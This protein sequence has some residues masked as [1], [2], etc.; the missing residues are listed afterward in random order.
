MD[1]SGGADLSVRLRDGES[2]V[3]EGGRVA[4]HFSQRWQR[5]GEVD[6]SNLSLEIG[7][8]SHTLV[9]DGLDSRGEGSLK[10]EVRI[11]GEAEEVG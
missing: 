2:L 8:G 6:A 9:V 7:P 11:R 4:T 1:G 10:V 3:Y 5:L